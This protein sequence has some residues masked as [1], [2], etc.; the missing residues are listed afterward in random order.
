M[1]LFLCVDFDIIGIV[2][3]RLC[4]ESFI[5]G[6]LGI[7]TGYLTAKTT[8]EDTFVLQ[9]RQ[10]WRQYLRKWVDKLTTCS[11]GQTKKLSKLRNALIVRINPYRDVHIMML[12]DNIID[13]SIAFP[14]AEDKA[15]LEAE[16][17]ALKND[18]VFVISLLLKKD[19]E[20]VKKDSSLFLKFGSINLVVCILFVLLIPGILSSFFTGDLQVLLILLADILVCYV[21]VV[22]LIESNVNIRYYLKENYFAKIFNANKQKFRNYIDTLPKSISVNEKHLDTHCWCHMRDYIIFLLVFFFAVALQYVIYSV[23]L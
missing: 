1:A 4:M 15:Q 6:I 8:R 20:R 13:V 5:V 16:F 22:I 12:L 11:I 23:V 17:D 3:R 19:W 7:F 10:V 21:G 9:D 2:D 18:L 14:S